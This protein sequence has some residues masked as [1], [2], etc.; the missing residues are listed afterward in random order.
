MGYRRHNRWVAVEWDET[1][2]G[3]RISAYHVITIP[4]SGL[5]NGY[6]SQASASA[7]RNREA[8]RFFGRKRKPRRVRYDLSNAWIWLHD[9]AMHRRVERQCG[10]K[11]DRGLPIIRH[12]SLWDFYNAIGYD[13]KRDRYSV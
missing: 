7:Y 1:V 5:K 6:V 12:A 11:F 3:G 13:H 10:E 8:E 4:G 2:I 9:R